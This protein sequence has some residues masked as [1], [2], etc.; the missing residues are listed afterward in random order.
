MNKQHDPSENSVHVLT[1]E[2]MVSVEGGIV[3]DKQ[4]YKCDYCQRTDFS[5]H[6]EW[7]IHVRNCPK[8][9]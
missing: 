3:D 1:D 9:N 6:I 7:L 4:V 2:E 8:R 5:T